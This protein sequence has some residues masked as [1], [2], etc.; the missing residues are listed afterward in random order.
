MNQR[1][2][3]VSVLVDDYDKA[4]DYYTRV[5]GFDLIDDRPIEHGKR[6]VLVR[7]AGSEGTCLLLAQASGPRQKSRV[8]DQTGGRVFL[9]LHTDDFDRD[10]EV[11]RSRGVEFCEEPRQESYGRVAVFNDIFGNKWDLLQLNAAD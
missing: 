11:Y 8:G 7:P 4:V 9:F 5:L 3:Y 10:Y 1:I 6:W 2:S